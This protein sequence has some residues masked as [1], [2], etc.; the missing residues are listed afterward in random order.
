LGYGFSGFQ[1]SLADGVHDFNTAK[2]TARGPKGLQ[3]QH[4]AYLSFHR[5][6][7]LLHKAIEIFGVPDDKGRLVN[8]VVMLNRGRIRATLI[9]GDFFW[10]PLGTNRLA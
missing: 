7:V 8:L 3:S 2:R 5:T 6:M 9:D 1:L 4:R 10:E